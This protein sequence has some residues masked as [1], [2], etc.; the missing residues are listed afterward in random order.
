MPCYTSDE[1]STEISSCNTPAS[2][3]DVIRIF[4]DLCESITAIED[5]MLRRQRNTNNA[6]TT[7][8]A[9]VET[10]YEL[11]DLII[12]E[13]PLGSFTA[14]NSIIVQYDGLYRI[15]YDASFINNGSNNQSCSL[16]IKVN[17]TVEVSDDT[18][19]AAV[20]VSVDGE[21]YRRLEAGDIISAHAL[22]ATSNR[23][24]TLVLDVEYLM[25]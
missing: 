13:T 14:P 17:G 24:S 11:N 22:V 8:V 5:I 2:R 16:R 4:A 6:S 9:N 1:L 10:G 20:P 18:L 15:N 21:F 23:T 25:P 19:S 7:M 3:A 12:R